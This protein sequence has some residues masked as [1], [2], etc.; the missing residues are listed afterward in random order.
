MFPTLRQ[1]PV[2]PSPESRFMIGRYVMQPC[3]K[4]RD[5]CVSCIVCRDGD[6]PICRR[7][8]PVTVKTQFPH[9]VSTTFNMQ[10]KLN[11]DDFTEKQITANVSDGYAFSQWT[12]PNKMLACL[13][14]WWLVHG[15]VTFQNIRY[16]LSF[17]M[18]VIYEEFCKKKISAIR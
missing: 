13:Y 12:T 14:S 1:K 6:S 10:K 3:Y 17:S 4:Y 18:P 9:N 2:Q 5:L 15:L 16:S 11:Q 8:Y 7:G